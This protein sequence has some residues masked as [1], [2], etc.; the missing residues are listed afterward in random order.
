MNEWS[1]YFCI[2]PMCESQGM[3]SAKTLGRIC[4]ALGED[5]VV[6]IDDR[7]G[8]GIGKQNIIPIF[9]TNKAKQESME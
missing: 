2:T 8:I 1:E 7:G 5:Y 6:R 9:A 3:I 4:M